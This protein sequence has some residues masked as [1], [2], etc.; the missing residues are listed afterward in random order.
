MP[1]PD[2]QGDMQITPMPELANYI[3]TA[4]TSP[5]PEEVVEKAKHHLLDTLS[6]MVSGSRMLAGERAIAFVKAQGQ[7]EPQAALAGT[8]LRTTAINA[9]MANGMFAHADETD[10]SH[11]PSLTHPGCGVVPAVLACAELWRRGGTDMLRAMVLGYDVCAR[12]TMSLDAY[13]FREAGHSSHTFGPNFG[14]AAAAGALAGVEARQ[15]RYLMSYAAQQASG[16]ACWM[17]DKDHVEKSF[18]FGGMG[19]RNGVTAAIMVHSGCT[20]VD[21]VFSGQRCF[22]DA[23]GDQPD[24]GALGRELGVRYEILNTAIKRWTVG[25][26]IQAPLDALDHL[27]RTHRFGADDV[28]AVEVRIPHQMVLTVNNRD[29]PEICLQHVLATLIVD[30]TMGF[31][32]AHDRSR[33]NDPTVLAVRERIALVGDDGLSRLMPSRQGI[34]EVTLKDGRRLREHTLAVRGTPANP[35]TRKELKE[36]SMELIAPILGKAQGER[37]VEQVWTLERIESASELAQ[38]LSPAS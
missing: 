32:S 9:A 4:L 22:Y 1:T 3:A 23:Y 25:S 7:S 38:L 10:D 29:M 37:L 35:M 31:A 21:D 24:R 6:S 30:G 12:L 15:A 28:L 34:V 18:D 14:A 33:M 36:K 8:S 20:G 13:A 11:A 19:A 5:L 26:P 16:V 27:I 17:R 2:A